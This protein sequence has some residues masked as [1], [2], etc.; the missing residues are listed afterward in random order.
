MWLLSF[1]TLKSLKI[2]KRQK[3]VFF[4]FV[5]TLALALVSFIPL[6]YGQ[7]LGLI[8]LP[9]LAVLGVVFLLKLEVRLLSVL[10]VVTPFALS[11]STGLVQYLFPHTLWWFKLIFWLSFFIIFYALLLSLNIFR[12]ASSRQEIPLLRP[13]KTTLFLIVVLISFYAFSFLFKALVTL[14]PQAIFVVL[15][16]YIL[17]FVLFSLFVG[18]G[19]RVA[20]SSLLAAWICLEVFLT[21]SFF[22]LKSFF[23]GL[24]L[25][26]TFYMVLS[27]ERE[28]FLHRL[29]GRL[30]WEC[31]ALILGLG[32]VILGFG[33]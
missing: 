27:L 23:R 21:L 14:L 22:P 2:G 18:V 11:L 17:S 10:Y 19:K 30:I 33:S 20:G 3:F 4:S 12:V 26:T 25:S 9:V 8:A 16:S 13:A 6:G 5:L 24:M 15:F 31:F 29:N 1:A 28:Y 7:F 32:A